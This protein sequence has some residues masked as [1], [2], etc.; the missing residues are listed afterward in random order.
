MRLITLVTLLSALVLAGQAAAK[1]I[2]GATVC[3]DSGCEQVPD[4]SQ[5]Q[6]LAEVGDGAGP[7]GAAAPFY[8]V[9]VVVAESD[10]TRLTL[11]SLY[12]P[13]ERKV[14]AKPDG[15]DRVAWFKALPQY[16]NVLQAIA[17]QAKPFPASRFPTAPT[18]LSPKAVSPSS[19][20]TRLPLVP[21]GVAVLGLIAMTAIAVRLGSRVRHRADRGDQRAPQPKAEM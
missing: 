7:P 19:H 17:A 2:K 18:S 14:G 13:S 11:R 15:S 5:S 10:G 3:G 16:V 9:R 8:T 6:W 20:G 12:V 4:S 21:I 1:D